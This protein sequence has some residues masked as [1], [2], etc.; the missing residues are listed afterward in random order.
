MASQPIDSGDEEQFGLAPYD[1]P[2]SQD[3]MGNPNFD[4]SELWGE[5]I[6]A[7]IASAPGGYGP[8]WVGKR[9]L[10]Q[11]GFG[12]AGLWELLDDEGNVLQVLIFVPIET[13]ET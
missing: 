6:A 4:D 10:G 8:G 3:V 11:G 5:D 2:E 12:R 1:A 13:F 7:F 9:P